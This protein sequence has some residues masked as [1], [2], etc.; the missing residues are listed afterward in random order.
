MKKIEIEDVA[1]LWRFE[2]EVFRIDF[3]IRPGQTSVYTEINLLNGNIIN[4]VEGKARI[5]YN[6]QTEEQS[7]WIEEKNEVKLDHLAL[8]NDEL[9]LELPHGKYRFLRIAKM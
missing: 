5:H 7:I 3:S 1:G 4:N 9:I 8:D 2:D 6:S